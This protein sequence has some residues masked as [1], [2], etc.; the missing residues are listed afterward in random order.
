[1]QALSA[2]ECLALLAMRSV[3][4][5][6]V[7]IEGD[8]PLV[9]PVNY[10]LSGSAVVF[11]TDPGTKLDALALGPISFQ[12]DEIDP[13]HRTG[14]SVLVRGRAEAATYFESGHLKLEPW[15]GGAKEH[16]FRIVAHSV[17]GRRIALPEFLP[18]QKGYL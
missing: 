16:W 5:I 18:N 9:I 15:A 6:A 13:L 12:L 14:W 17:T 1:L 3:G 4:R 7:N 10:V 2:D 11:R 8:G